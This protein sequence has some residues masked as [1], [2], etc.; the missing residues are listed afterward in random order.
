MILEAFKSMQFCLKNGERNGSELHVSPKHLNVT[1]FACH[2]FIYP[3]KCYGSKGI[4][5]LF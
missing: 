4:L 1:S 3:F 5:E 2:T